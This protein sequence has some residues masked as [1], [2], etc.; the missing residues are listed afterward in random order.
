ML[1]YLLN[2]PFCPWGSTL[3]NYPPCSPWGCLSF[4][5]ILCYYL[6][7]MVLSSQESMRLSIVEQQLSSTKVFTEQIEREASR[8]EKI[9]SD[10][11][12]ILYGQVALR[13][14]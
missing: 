14:E 7:Y 9:L 6:L 12:S 10:Q 11:V 4:L 3:S 13:Q 2:P 8:F 1:Y 5:L